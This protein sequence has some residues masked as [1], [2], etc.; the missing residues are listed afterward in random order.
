MSKKESGKAFDAKI[1]MRI[2]SFAKNYRIHFIIATLAVITTSLLA[3]ARPILLK[4]AV[5][6][7]T[8]NKNE[9]TL[10]YYTLVMLV[11]LIAEVVLQVLFIYFAN[12]IG[13]HI[14]RDMRAKIFRHI[15]QF[16]MS[17]FD[18]T[19]V[20]RL[21]TRVVSDIETIAS[22]FSQGLFMI[23]SDVLQMLVVIVAMLFINWQLALIAL[24]VLPILI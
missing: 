11:V 1:F 18:T 4:E 17:Y 19:S 10:L 2:L 21:V 24:A 20:G 5:K 8:T 13:Q 9:E 22:S 7:F 3:V 15:L 6:D 23:I 14:I 12:W 16:K